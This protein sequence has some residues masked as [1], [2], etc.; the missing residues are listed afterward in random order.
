M[1]EKN[2]TQQKKVR[3]R[4][5]VK[6][7]DERRHLLTEAERSRGFWTAI[8]VWGVGIGDKLYA[9]GR[10]RTYRKARS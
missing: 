10:W 2:T 7:N 4:P 9:A 6:G 5:F 1:P 8:A 3:G